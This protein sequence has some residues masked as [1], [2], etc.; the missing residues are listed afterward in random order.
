MN[1]NTLPDDLRTIFA[2]S[3]P[4]TLLAGN[5]HAWQTTPVL[6]MHEMNCRHFPHCRLASAYCVPAAFC[7]LGSGEEP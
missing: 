5:A 7:L 3:L 6:N 4:G 1:P 2:L